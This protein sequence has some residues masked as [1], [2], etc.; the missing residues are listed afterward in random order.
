MANFR[1]AVVVYS[2]KDFYSDVSDCG[3]RLVR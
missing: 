1:P 3:S 2:G